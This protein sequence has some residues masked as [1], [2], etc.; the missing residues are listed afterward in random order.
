MGHKQSPIEWDQAFEA[1]QSKL[2][3]AQN[4]EEKFQGVFTQ[5]RLR[6]ERSQR[7]HINASGLADKARIEEGTARR[8]LNE[9]RRQRDSAL[10]K[11]LP[12]QRWDIETRRWEQEVL[13]LATDIRRYEDEA[14]RKELEAKAVSEEVQA[15]RQEL[16]RL[17]E[18]TEFWES[19]VKYLTQVGTSQTAGEEKQSIVVNEL[20][21]PMLA[22][23]LEDM[24]HGS[25]QVLRLILDSNGEARLEL[26]VPTEGD[27][28]IE[29]Q[30]N[31]VLLIESPLPEALV[32]KMLDVIETPE[33]V[34]F[35][36]AQST[37][38]PSTKEN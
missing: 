34:R 22:Q 12:R 24:E 38:H 9:A 16:T 20:V 15:Q 18:E 1:A 14:R 30:G 21:P 36:L 27:I 17:A 13:R 7:F 8:S 33:G 5:T 11:G 10:L 25:D 3:N 26:D 32:G 19:R 35:T 29:H 37:E 28:L 6:L 4:A 2:K 23:I 31:V